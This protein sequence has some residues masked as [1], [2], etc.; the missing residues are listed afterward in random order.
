MVVLMF[1][2]AHVHVIVPAK[3]MVMRVPFAGRLPIKVERT[4]QQ[5]HSSGD[6]RKPGADVITQRDAEARDRKTEQRSDDD[7]ACSCE[8]GHCER[9]RMTPT[10]RSR[11]KDEWQPVR[12][13]RGMEEGNAEPRDRDGGEDAVVHFRNFRCG[14]PGRTDYANTGR[15]PRLCALLATLTLHLDLH[16]LFRALVQVHVKVQD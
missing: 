14:Q 4:Q 3:E 2:L 15:E 6:P 13:N 5:K 12:R 10:L 1:Q 11:R 7:M 8:C 16:L 9:L